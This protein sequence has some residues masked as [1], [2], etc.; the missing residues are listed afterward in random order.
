MRKIDRSHIK[1]VE[2]DEAWALLAQ[3][4]KERDIDDVKDALNKYL[5]H[6][7]MMTYVELHE[8]LRAQEMNMWLIATERQL[9]HTFTNMDL[10]GNV[11]KKYTVSYRFS[12]TPE[13]PREAPGWP[14]SDEEILERLTDAGEVVD[15][16]ARKCRNC[17]EI[18]HMTKDCPNEKT[19]R[20]RVSIMC[21]N[22]NEV[23]HRVRD[24]EF[25]KMSFLYVYKTD[26]CADR[27]SS[28]RPY[29]ASRQVCVQE[30]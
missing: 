3:A 2:P 22:C 25:T 11:G 20:D 1:N 18:G 15:S 14:T 4:I 13:R 12:K 21:I 29:C 19:E 28:S 6:Y 26:D 8:A 5:K 23:G 24:C 30:L 17:D 9:L 16:G 27:I 7:P 10:Q